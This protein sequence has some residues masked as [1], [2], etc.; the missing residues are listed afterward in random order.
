MTKKE[1]EL[2]RELDGKLDSLILKV[3]VLEQQLLSAQGRSKWID[4]IVAS[5]V[6]ATISSCLWLYLKK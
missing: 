2:F 5:I 6:S 4:R 1:L 3:A